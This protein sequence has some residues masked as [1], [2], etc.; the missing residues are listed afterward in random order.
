MSLRCSL[1]L[2]MNGSL[3]RTGIVRSWD[4]FIRKVREQYFV[5]DVV[6]ILSTLK[7]M[8]KFL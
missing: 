5:D 7:K 8:L 6:I 3:E 4:L 1:A 2:Q